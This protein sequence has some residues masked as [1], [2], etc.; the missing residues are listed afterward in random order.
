MPTR[1]EQDFAS[2]LLYLRREWIVQR[3]GWLCMVLFIAAACSGVFGGQGVF[4]VRRGSAT[5]LQVEYDRFARY[6]ADTALELTVGKA[7]GG[8]AIV[9]AD[10]ALLRNFAI[11]S[12]LPEPAMTRGSGGR[13]QFTFSVERLP[14]TITIRLKPHRV[15]SLQGLFQL[16][17]A[18]P[19]QVEQF[20]YP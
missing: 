3:I 8:V 12:I 6:A 14:T 5:A 18:A 16:R 9:E 15:G 7:S 19:I 4:T 1:E 20:V 10:A 17:S 2:E 13:L 11:V